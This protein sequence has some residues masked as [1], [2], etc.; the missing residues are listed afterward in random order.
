MCYTEEVNRYTPLLI[1]LVLFSFLLSSCTEEEEIVIQY[2]THEDGKRGALEERLIAEFE[3]ENP[4]IKVERTEFQSSELIYKVSSSMEAGL[5]PV[6]FN[7]SSEV[8][9]ELAMSGSL[10]KLPDGIISADDYIPGAFDAVTYG[11]NI[12]GIP[13]EYTNW[14]LYVN[15]S[16]LEEAG[17]ELPETWEDIRDISL[18]L[19]EHDGGIITKRVFD[20]RYPYYLSFFIPMVMQLGGGL[21]SDG[22]FIVNDDAWIEALSFMKEWGPLGDNLGSPTLLNARSLFNDEKIAMCLSGLYQ[23]ERM[24]DMNPEFYESPRWKVLPFPSFEVALSDV[25]ASSYLH[26]F[27]V[28]EA[29]SGE[30]KMAGWKLAS[31]FASHA[32][33]YLEEVGLVMPLKTIINGDAVINKPYGSVFIDDLKRSTPVYSG[34]YAMEIQ[35]LIGEAV[36]SVMLQGISPEKAVAQLRASVSYLFI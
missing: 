20:F 24:K 31:Y 1:L 26:F 21:V 2:W 16:M 17:L 13:L 33:E 10:D 22:S 28:N 36:E 14:C 19:T 30:E 4:G 25:S 23:E 6:L 29:R 12:Y 7:L 11:D 27:M 15:T 35:D 32:D 18:L 5:G 8:I 34:P 3:I 9:P